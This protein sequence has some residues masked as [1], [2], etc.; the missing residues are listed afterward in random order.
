VNKSILG[1]FILYTSVCFSQENNFLAK[2]KINY[3]PINFDSI[4]KKNITKGKKT[5]FDKMFLSVL[6]TLKSSSYELNKIQF[7]LEYNKSASVFH[8]KPL[9]EIDANRLH[10]L[11]TLLGIG[12][13][14][15]KYF[16][17][18]KVTIN[19]KNSFGQDFLVNTP[20]V[21][22]ILSNISKK[23][24]QYECYKATTEVEKRNS[25]GISIKKITA[26]FCPKIP[27]NFG[28]KYYSGLPGLIVKLQDRNYIEYELV[29]IEKTKKRTIKFPKKG[30]KISYV[31]FMKLSKKMFDNRKN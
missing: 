13:K 11:T 23:I 30:K 14:G 9:L 8:K 1:V 10:L 21:N 18:S 6:K 12:I 20:K 5:K 25:S 28:P 31:D 16:V 26:W 3:K 27:F 17:N 19:Q 7:V 2:Y 29:K 4:A 15:E 24:G 22:W